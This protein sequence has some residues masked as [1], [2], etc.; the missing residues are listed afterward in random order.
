MLY[1]NG[2]SAK[3]QYNNPNTGKRLKPLLRTG[4]P[5]QNQQKMEKVLILT[6]YWPPSGGPGVQRWLKFARYLPESG[7]EPVIITVDPQQATYPLT[8]NDLIKEVPEMIRVYHTP[9][10]EPYALYKKFFGKKQVPYSGFANEEN[11]GIASR[12]SRFIRGNLFIPDARKGW[13]PYAIAQ[14]SR[15]IKELNIRY[16]IT[17][18]PPHSTQ[19]AGLELK[20]RFPHIRWI[21]D[22]RDPWT[23]I[24]YYK[25][26]L[27]LPRAKEKDLKLEKQ[28]LNQADGVVTVSNPIK[29]L[30]ASKMETRHNLPL[31]VI[32]NGFDESDF[33]EI[34][35]TPDPSFF[36][37]TYTGTLTD[38]YNLS[39]FIPAVK[40][41]EIPA[42]KKLRL[43]FVGS[44]CNRW[45]N[46][47]SRNFAEEVSFTSHVSHPRAIEFMKQAD[48]LLLVIPQITH[49]EG[50]L[51][52]K[53]FEYLA[54]RRPI[55]GIGPVHGE[56]AKI[57]SE[58]KAGKMMDYDDTKAISKYMYQTIGQKH[59][60]DLQAIN[61]YSRREL[62]TKLARL[63]CSK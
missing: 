63:L 6:Y 4:Y 37:L 13:N 16:L 33:L 18:S 54:A 14:A 24:F 38:D 22:L 57:L 48:V 56:A 41:T 40:R 9:T 51:T 46:E 30:F 60:P 21:A 53:L 50:I 59:T 10:R 23:D 32:P 49:N 61:H 17:T 11:N 42:G 31:V 58:T 26:M 3:T 15:L 35:A 55:M 19:L 44:I 29:E 2:R 27:H 47:L 1:W 5:R 62:T 28:V 43:R 45:M 20:K 25:K 36:T 52:G 7:Y 8:D 34:P 39:G 12:I